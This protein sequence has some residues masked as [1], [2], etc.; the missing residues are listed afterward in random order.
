MH[1]F[2]CLYLLKKINMLLFT[3][4]VARVIC[5][6]YWFRTIAERIRVVNSPT[7]SGREP[8]R[9]L[10][11]APKKPERLVTSEKFSNVAKLFLGIFLCI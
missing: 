11:H 4:L 7:S 3:N 1:I 5:F 8:A 2:K 9:S 10:N 6:E